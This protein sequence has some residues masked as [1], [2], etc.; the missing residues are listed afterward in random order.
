MFLGVHCENETSRCDLYNVTCHN[1][2]VCVDDVNN[3]TCLCVRGFAGDLCDVNI[4]D[5]ENHTCQHNASCVDG[6]GNY[7]CRLVYHFL[8]PWVCE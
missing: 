8:Y 2:G 6:I 5:C 4:D 7:I 3:Y 1:D